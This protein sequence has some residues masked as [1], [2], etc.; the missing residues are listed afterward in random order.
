M[1]FIQINRS[2]IATGAVAAIASIVISAVLI[3]AS[4]LKSLPIGSGQQVV[5]VDPIKIANAQRAAAAQIIGESANKD[6]VL[7]DVFQV[8]RR[9]QAILEEQSKGRTVLVKQAVLS[10]NLTDITDDILKAAGLPTN[11][12]SID[13]GKQLQ[14]APTSHLHSDSNHELNTQNSGK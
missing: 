8:S 1:N 12:P 5:I 6:V 9:V 13:I 4:D 10:S 11:V 2:H 3:H 14:I 7:S